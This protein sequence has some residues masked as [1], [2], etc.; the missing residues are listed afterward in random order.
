[1]YTI[2]TCPSYSK[3]AIYEPACNHIMLVSYA[4]VNIIMHSDMQFAQKADCSI[5]AH[6]SVVNGL[7]Q[8]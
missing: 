8:I 4:A 1:M 7:L 5:I 3:I 6:Q 2:T